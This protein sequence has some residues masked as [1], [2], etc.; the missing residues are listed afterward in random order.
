MTKDEVV[1]MQKC[2]M[3]WIFETTTT[4]RKWMVI[5]LHKMSQTSYSSNYLVMY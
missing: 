2:H 3:F 4:M 1:T 5:V